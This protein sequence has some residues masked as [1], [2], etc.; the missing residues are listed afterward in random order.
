MKPYSIIQLKNPMVLKLFGI[1]RVLSN[2][3]PYSMIRITEQTT[4][5]YLRLAET[6]KGNS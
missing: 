4:W 1:L 6:Y 3:I 2:K 5:K